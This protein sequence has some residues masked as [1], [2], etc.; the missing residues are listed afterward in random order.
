VG[1]DDYRELDLEGAKSALPI[2]TD[3]MKRATRMGA[4]RN[5]KEFPMPSG[6]TQAQ[7]CSESGKL[8]TDQ[9]PD[10]RAEY[11]ISGTEPTEKC[12]LHQV[13][14]SNPIGAAADSGSAPS[15]QE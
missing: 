13:E 10:S 7:I 3:F 6:I 8:A 5:A 12:D 14:A 2:W 1:F 4:Y 15:P 11:F 9:C